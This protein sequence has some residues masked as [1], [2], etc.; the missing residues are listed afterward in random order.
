MKVQKDL[1]AYLP[2]LIVYLFLIFIRSSEPFGDEFRYMA[3]AQNLWDGHYTDPNNPDLTN[4]PG[5][6]IIIL[7]FVILNLSSWAI[8]LNAFFAFFALIY[9][10]RTLRLYIKGKYAY[11]F[12]YFLGI[13]PPLLKMMS[14]LYSEAFSILLICGLIYHFCSLNGNKDRWAAGV[15]LGVL[16][17]TKIIFFH[18]TVAGLIAYFIYTILNKKRLKPNLVVFVIGFL[19]CSPYIW[20]AYSVTEKPFYVG[21]RGGELLYHRSTPYENEWGNWVSETL[22]LNPD[23]A[24]KSGKEPYFALNQLSKNHREFYLSL[25][26]LSNIQKDSA[27]KA[28]ARLN[29]REHPIKYL[30]NSISNIGRLLFNHP[31]SYRIESINIYGYVL[32]NMLIVSI[33]LLLAYPIYI[34]RKHVP[35]EIWAI[36][37][38][39]FIYTGAIVI[40]HG[41]PRYFL[42]TV[43][44]LIF[45]IAYSFQNILTI[46][47]KGN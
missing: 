16:M 5:Y 27:F 24:Q 15:F 37:L 12:T 17:L 43:P 8:Y 9:F 47:I 13:Y 2:F 40:L 14:F 25:E 39:F 23:E 38:Y 19:F 36:V 3:Y 31:N 20:Y 28:K 30:K 45:L 4:G 1:I 7:P 26:G 22:I 29:M 11:Y 18:I 35:H 41:K 44:S 33:L 32:P 21:T 42:L 46:R 34:S 10:H 6:P